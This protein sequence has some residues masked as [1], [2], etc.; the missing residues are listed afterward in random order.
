MA[1]VTAAVSEWLPAWPAGLSPM[2]TSGDGQ[3]RRRR[4]LRPNKKVPPSPQR[5]AKRSSPICGTLGLDRCTRRGGC[6]R[7]WPEILFQAEEAAFKGVIAEFCNEEHS[8]HRQRDDQQS[9]RKG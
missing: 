1:P 5:N 2:E 9:R 7:T 4:G 8:T 6:I 3:S